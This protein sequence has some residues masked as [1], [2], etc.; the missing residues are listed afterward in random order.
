MEWKFRILVSEIEK[1]KIENISIWDED[2][3]YTGEKATVIDPYCGREYSSEIVKVIKNNTVV[4]FLP[5]E[6]SNN[7][8]GIYLK[9][10]SRIS[11]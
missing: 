9:D 8:W 11:K 7:V 5:I 1:V 3:I 10:N 4:F 2:W 6:F